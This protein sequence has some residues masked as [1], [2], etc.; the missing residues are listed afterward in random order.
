[1]HEGIKVA[2][3]ASNAFIDGVRVCLCAEIGYGFFRA[4]VI[5]DFPEA[6]ARQFFMD[7]ALPRAGLKMTLSEEDWAKVQE[8]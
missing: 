3:S 1:M 6:E 4:E 2:V 5:G 8:V 7:C